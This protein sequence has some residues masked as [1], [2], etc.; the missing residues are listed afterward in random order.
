MDESMGRSAAIKDALAEWAAQ[1]QIDA[2]SSAFYALNWEEVDGDFISRRAIEGLAEVYARHFIGT[3]QGR[4]IVLRVAE[5]C[6]LDGETFGMPG[7][8][9]GIIAGKIAWLQAAAD[10]DLV[11]RDN[12]DFDDRV[13]EGLDSAEIERAV[14]E[15][16]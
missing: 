7:K 1:D 3:Q 8:V 16:Y 11:F 13:M 12:D 9:V 2:E 4:A 6:G 10:F 14:G 5:E 15:L